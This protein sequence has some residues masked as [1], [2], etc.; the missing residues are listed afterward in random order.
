VN[1]PWTCGGL[2]DGD[3]LAAFHHVVL[4]IASEFAPDLLIVSAGFDAAE[5]D[6]LGG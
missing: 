3:Y 2:G 6:P 5:G 1:V 4:P